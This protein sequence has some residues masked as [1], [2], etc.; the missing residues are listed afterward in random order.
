M[1][2]SYTREWFLFF[3]QS[4]NLSYY[5]G[6]AARAACSDFVREC[7]ERKCRLFTFPIIWIVREYV[8]YIVDFVEDIFEIFQTMQFIFKP[9]ST[10]SVLLVS[11]I[12][13]Q[14]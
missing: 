7:S 1:Q 9:A 5:A 6:K 4:D 14:T 3:M 11:L 13:E 2:S 10:W 12:F 8:M